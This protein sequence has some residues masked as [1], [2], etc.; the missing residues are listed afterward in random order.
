MLDVVGINVA[1]GSNMTPEESEINIRPLHHDDFRDIYQ[2]TDKPLILGNVP[3]VP[4]FEYSQLS[5]WLDRHNPADH[6]FVAETKD[7]VLG[8]VILNQNLRPRLQHS[9]KIAMLTTSNPVYLHVQH[10]LLSKALDF[11][12][13][14]LNITRVELEV[15][16]NR[17]AEIEDII[18]LGFRKE[19][20]KKQA[21]YGNGEWRD[22]LLLA[23]IQNVQ[24]RPQENAI[25]DGVSGRWRSTVSPPRKVEN[26]EIRPTEISDSE[27]FHKIVLD[28]AIC[29]TTLQLPSQE[30]WRIE[31]KLKE[32]A[33]WLHRFTALADGDIV[34]SIVMVQDQSPGRN[35][36]GHIGMKV[37]RDYWGIGIGTKLMTT[38]TDL[39]D[40]WLNVTRLELEV[41]TD[42]PAGIRLYEKTGF[43]IEGTKRLQAYGDG[44]WADSHFMARIRN[45]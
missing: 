19:G 1:N 32:S 7:G 39:V 17:K 2:V 25:G 18:D 24:D 45:K 42:N 35:H 43:V 3:V 40:G 10:A 11:A 21:V 31:K 33:S 44:R 8:L 15:D 12:D 28:P 9:G 29:R 41:N 14:W 23:R 4:G 30:F 6:R 16:T 27:A 5:E 34:G 37:H 38:V 36:T 22:L 26:V 20:T 13:N